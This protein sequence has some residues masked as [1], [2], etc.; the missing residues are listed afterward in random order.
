[1]SLRAPAACTP[2]MAR[3]GWTPLQECWGGHHSSTWSSPHGDT[4]FQFERRERV[5]WRK[6]HRWLPLSIEREETERPGR[7]GRPPPRHTSCVAFFLTSLTSKGRLRRAFDAVWLRTDPL[8]A[9]RTRIST[10]PES[11]DLVEDLLPTLYVWI[12]TNGLFVPINRLA[13]VIPCWPSAPR[14]PDTGSA[15][16]SESRR[17]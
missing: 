9:S 2:Y 13:R 4:S 6:P 5:C 14:H 11:G 16:P 12:A 1:L 15:S 8:P 17:S 10:A 3:S 7:R